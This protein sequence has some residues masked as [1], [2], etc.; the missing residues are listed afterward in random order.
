M[1]STLSSLSSQ[2]LIKIFNYVLHPFEFCN[3]RVRNDR[4]Y[5]YIDRYDNVNN[6]V[7]RYGLLAKRFAR[8][9]VPRLTPRLQL[10]IQDGQD[11]R[12]MLRLA[13]HG[14]LDGRSIQF[15]HIDVTR[16]SL[17]KQRGCMAIKGVE[18]PSL[19]M[20]SMPLIR[21]ISIES[22]LSSPNFLLSLIRYTPLTRL[23][24]STCDFSVDQ[25][26]DLVS[27]LTALT[28]T[29][30]SS[31]KLFH[32]LMISHIVQQQ[33]SGDSSSSGDF[34][35][36]LTDRYLQSSTCYQALTNLSITGYS[37][38]SLISLL[39]LPNLRLTKLKL[40]ATSSLDEELC[41]C[42]A[43]LVSLESFTFCS[44]KIDFR[45]T[46]LHELPAQLPALTK[47]NLSNIFQEE[48]SHLSTMPMPRPLSFFPIFPSL[49][50]LIL[51]H[52][53]IPESLVITIFSG[54]QQLQHLQTLIIES[55]YTITTTAMQHLA[56]FFATNK[57][58]ETIS[59]ISLSYDEPFDLIFLALR[60]HPALK[61]LRFTPFYKN[62]F[63][64]N[65]KESKDIEQFID[66]CST[67]QTFQFYQVNFP[68]SVMRAL[69]THQGLHTIEVGKLTSV[70]AITELLSTNHSI[71]HV[72]CTLVEAVDVDVLAFLRS[73]SQL[74]IGELH[75][76]SLYLIV[77]SEELIDYLIDMLFLAKAPNYFVSLSL[78]LDPYCPDQAVNRL[79]NH[80]IPSY[81]NF[82][83]DNNNN[84]NNNNNSE[85]DSNIKRT[86]SLEKLSIERV[87]SV[88]Q[89]I[90]FG[91]IS[92]HLERT[93]QSQPQ[94]FP[95]K[96]DFLHVLFQ[97]N[98]LSEWE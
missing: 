89:P 6:V 24:L 31:L 20:P 63:Q 82:K 55:F 87:S 67:L 79:L 25:Y 19:T 5:C 23:S 93:Q 44:N 17:T 76:L 81:N 66:T 71:R 40:Y 18:L 46:S 49:N 84:N 26:P 35:Q 16:Y 8:D 33:S 4:S 86:T 53:N 57:S 54:L 91:R 65:D 34:I 85:D 74:K 30:L 1:T 64:L 43:R 72:K 78:K 83:D 80:I 27:V 48:A 96:E 13:Q 12:R 90:C 97:K 37:E 70:N 60:D 10:F 98:L 36:Q 45:S 56:K 15:G 28:S 9:I 75:T 29:T 95:I 92:K 52:F 22:M 38:H 61:N 21:S 69:L 88:K 2:L 59:L 73:I 62:R 41:R 3:N 77:S 94:P 11:L 47:L 7:A 32:P 68:P 58:L 51:S 42:I 50:T 39:K 14:L